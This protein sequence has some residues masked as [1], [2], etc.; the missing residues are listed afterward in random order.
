[1]SAAERSVDGTRIKQFTADNIVAFAQAFEE[2]IGY[3]FLPPRSYAKWSKITPDT[4]TDQTNRTMSVMIDLIFGD[5]W[6]GARFMRCPGHC[7][8]V[9]IWSTPKVPANHARAL[10]RAVDRCPHIKDEQ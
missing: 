3:F 4:T 7:P 10:R 5:P 1:V 9:S 8:Q 2:P 6:D